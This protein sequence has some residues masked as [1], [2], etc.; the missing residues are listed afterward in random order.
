MDEWAKAW[1]NKASMN[2]MNWWI[3]EQ[4]DELAKEG[5]NNAILYIGWN[6]EMNE[7]INRLISWNRNE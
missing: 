4:V 3:D 7:Y 2:T 1:M 5:I 6:N